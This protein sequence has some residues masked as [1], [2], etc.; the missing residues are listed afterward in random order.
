MTIRLIHRVQRL[1]SAD[2]H[3]F[4]ESLE[5]RALLLKQH[6][7]EAELEL[8]RK[9]ARVEALTEE[10]RRVG[11]TRQRI[12]DAV[13]RAEADTKLAMAEERDDLARFAIRRLLPRQSELAALDTRSRELA[14]ERARLA[15]KLTDQETE[16]EELRGRVRAQLARPEVSGDGEAFEPSVADEDI[17]M[18]LLRR[19]RVGGAS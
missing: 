18:E 15:A 7:R 16:F 12:E 4:V 9:R 10:E 8:Q 1:V 2:A 14:D 17:E 19:K 6:L 3:G 11:E 13:A 5:D